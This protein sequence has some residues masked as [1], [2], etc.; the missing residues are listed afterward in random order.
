MA[1]CRVCYWNRD[2]GEY[3]EERSGVIK[4]GTRC[5]S[6][7]IEL[8]FIRDEKD[9]QAPCPDFCETAEEAL[10]IEVGGGVE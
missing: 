1:D 3:P 6:S 8:G 9:C 2:K 10:M 4:W 7:R 5:H